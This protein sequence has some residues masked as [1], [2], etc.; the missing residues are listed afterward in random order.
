MLEWYTIL[1]RL[2]FP[3]Y[4][5]L[6]F[7]SH[8]NFLLRWVVLVTLIPSFESFLTLSFLSSSLSWLFD[9]FR[10]VFL[11]SL[12]HFFR[13]SLDPLLSFESPA[14]VCFISLVYLTL[15]HL[16]LYLSPL[17]YF[18]LPWVL[19]FSLLFPAHRF[20]SSLSWFFIFSRALSYSSL[21]FE[22]LWV[23]SFFLEFSIKHPGCLL[24]L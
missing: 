8:F 3:S 18:A 6:V 1:I 2:L 15:Y 9:S 12:L 7:L 4:L 16:E 5:Y 10:S 11:H 22:P 19:I 23:F 14:I 21:C 13:V 24:G 17:L 20:A